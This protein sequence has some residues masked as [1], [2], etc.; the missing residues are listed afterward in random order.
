[1][2]NNIV[3]RWFKKNPDLVI[4]P[5]I[6]VFVVGLMI[7]LTGGKFLNGLNLRSMAFQL[8]ELGLF[9]MAQMLALLASGINLSI[10]SSANLTGVV[11]AV[12]LTTWSGPDATGGAA[13]V[14]IVGTLFIG[15]V[16]ATVL[17][18]LNGLLIAYVGVSPVLTTLGTMIFYEGIT[19]AITKGYVISKFPEGFLVIG[20]GTLLGIPISLILLGVCA[21]LVGVILQYTPFGVRLRMLGSNVTASEFS[22]INVKAVLLRTYTLSGVLAG[23]SGIVM[24]SRFNSAN[25]GYGA[26]Y[27]LLTILISVLGGVS[28]MGGFGKVGG[29]VLALLILQFLSSGLNLLG[30]SAYITVAFWGVTMVLVIAYRY[31]SLRKYRR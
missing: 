11:M 4:L 5:F 20:N 16:C 26:S 22:C 23:L 15:L 25:V 13:A 7:V 3:Q 31:F 29:V 14:A 8:P 30:I 28:P 2:S 17:G 6:G 1:M 9:A 19:T 18:L 27:L 24:I 12:V 10:I 21:L